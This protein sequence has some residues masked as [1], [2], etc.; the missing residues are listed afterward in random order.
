[1]SEYLIVAWCFACFIVGFINGRAYQRG[2]TKKDS[3]RG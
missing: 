2:V 3:D 1:M